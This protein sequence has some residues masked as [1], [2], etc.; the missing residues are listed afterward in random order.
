MNVLMVVW[1]GW[2]LSDD[3]S[4][5][6]HEC[7]RWGVLNVLFELLI[8]GSLWLLGVLVIAGVWILNRPRD[9]TLGPAT[10]SDVRSVTGSDA[11][12][13]LAEAAVI[14]AERKAHGKSLVEAA[15]MSK[16]WSEPDDPLLLNVA[17]GDSGVRYWA[18]WPDGEDAIEAVLTRVPGVDEQDRP[19]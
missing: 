18:L 16:R 6:G 8:V 7:E 5:A 14:V 19:K 3:F 15:W 2:R 12:A 17:F 11:D 1:V 4:C 10:P 13:V 9:G